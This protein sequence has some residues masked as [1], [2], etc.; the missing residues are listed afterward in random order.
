M[1]SPPVNCAT[2]SKCCFDL[3]LV[4]AIPV[5]H[6]FDYFMYGAKQ[7]GTQSIQGI[8]KLSAASRQMRFNIPMGFSCAVRNCAIGVHFE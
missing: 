3:G 8:L 6:S 7:S 2:Q 4:V 5:A 1:I